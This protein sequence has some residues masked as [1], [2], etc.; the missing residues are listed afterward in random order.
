VTT[1]RL[2]LARQTVRSHE[3]YQGTRPA[4][5]RVDGTPRCCMFVSESANPPRRLL[6]GTAALSLDERRQ[7]PPPPVAADDPWRDPAD[8]TRCPLTP[9]TTFESPFPPNVWKNEFHAAT[10]PHALPGKCKHKQTTPT[11]RPGNFADDS[12]SGTIDLR[13]AVRRSSRLRTR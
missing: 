3:A 2:K 9:N 6:T 12:I 4:V 1:S 10:N 7:S 13:P 5:P 8:P 11:F